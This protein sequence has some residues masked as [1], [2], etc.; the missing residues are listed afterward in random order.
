MRQCSKKACEETGGIDCL[1]GAV[2]RSTVGKL[3]RHGALEITCFWCARANQGRP[4]SKARLWKK[5]ID[6]SLA[7]EVSNAVVNE[8]ASGSSPLG[9]IKVPVDSVSSVLPAGWENATGGQ[10]PKFARAV[11]AWKTLASQG[12]ESSET[13]R[14]PGKDK[15]K[16]SGSQR[17]MEQELLQMSQELWGEGSDG[18]ESSSDDG[19]TMVNPGTRHLAQANKNKSGSSGD[20]NDM[21]QKV[22]VQNLA[23]GQSPSDMVPL[24][25]MSMML[26]QQQGKKSRSKGKSKSLPSIALV[27]NNL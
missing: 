7:K 27:I 15:E 21:L 16:S 10:A 5:G 4:E 9:F 20:T 23:S 6:P 3:G 2:S 22:M 8:K 11:A 17:K 1:V 14:L 19:S 25:M 12:I 24:M 26:N 18:E 13:E